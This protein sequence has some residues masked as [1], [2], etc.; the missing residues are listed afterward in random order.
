MLLA[1]RG[2]VQNRP[3]GCMGGWRW[4]DLN[5]QV[6]EAGRPAG[7][8]SSAGVRASIVAWK[9]CNGWQ[10]AFLAATIPLAAGG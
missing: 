9:H 7:Y 6:H 2:S 1:M 5:G 4:N 3:A 10:R 8:E